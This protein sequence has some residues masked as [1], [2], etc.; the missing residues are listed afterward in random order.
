MGKDGEVDVS[1]IRANERIA[2]HNGRYVPESQVLIP[3]RDRGV[4][5]GDAVFDTTRSFGHR[6][7]K[8]REHLDRLYRSLRYLRLDPGLSPAELAGITEE[9]FERNLHLLNPDEDYWISQR[10]TRGLTKGIDSPF[11]QDGPTVIVECLTLPLRQR[12]RHFRDGIRVVTPP[13]RRTPPEALS[14]RAK[15]HNYLNLIQA[16]QEV[17]SL[18]PEAWA[19]LLDTSGNLCEGQGSNIFLVRDGELLTPRERFVLPGISR[20]TVIDHARQLEIPFREADL[21]LYDALTADEAFLTS[22]SLC[23][24]PVTTING[25]R[26]GRPD[27]VYGPVTQR[28]VD[29]YRQFVDHDFVA[30]YLKHLPEDGANPGDRW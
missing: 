8:V 28:L 13:S 3:F 18:D 20:Q 21:D 17:R 14:P 22:T 29:A 15:T 5:Y 25:Q 6:L 19:V 23:I 24:C 9:V 16:E 27:Q 2:W 30:Q 4:I 11:E 26:I 12:S 7:F 10:I 1:R